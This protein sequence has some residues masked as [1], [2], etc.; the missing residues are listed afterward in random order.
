MASG[1]AY[2]EATLCSSRISA[3]YAKK[4][5][6][7]IGTFEAGRD[8]RG[9]ERERLRRLDDRTVCYVPAS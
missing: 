7:V 1:S 8:F 4:G 3:E 5:L 6:D 2:G 9:G